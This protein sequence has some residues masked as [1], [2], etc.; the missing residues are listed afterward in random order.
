MISWWAGVP[1]DAAVFNASFLERNYL[2]EIAVDTGLVYPG[3]RNR[4]TVRIPLHPPMA[5]VCTLGG[6]TTVP[7][8][9]I[10][11]R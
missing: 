11:G 7:A 4:W 2:D 6:T 5:S 8:V 9:A 1:P 10:L 3:P